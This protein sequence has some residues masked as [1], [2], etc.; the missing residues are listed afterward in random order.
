MAKLRADFIKTL[1]EIKAELV[2]IDKK[3]ANAPLV[4]NPP[5]KGPPPKNPPAKAK[6]PPIKKTK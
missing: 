3:G 6:V 4:K 5:T 2:K 1:D